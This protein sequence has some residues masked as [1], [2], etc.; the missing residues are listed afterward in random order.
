MEKLETLLD[1]TFKDKEILRLALTHPSYSQST[2]DPNKHYQRLE[3]LGDAILSFILA[4]HLYMLFP[5][6]R[7]GP[8]AKYR[9]ALA[10][11]SF[12]AKLGRR[13]GLSEHIILS[14]AEA[15]TGGAEK[16]SILEDVLEAI[17]AA[18]Y[19]DSDLETTRSTVISWYGDIKNCLDDELKTQNPKGQ[20][21]ELIQK[22]KPEA[23]LKYTLVTTRG[24]D[25]SK[26]YT[27]ELSLDNK[28]L[29]TGSGPSKKE[30]EEAAAQEL[31]ISLKSSS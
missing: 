13:L 18:I 29:A 3:F 9:S 16:D 14:D 30:A 22:T 4:D 11:G 25:H 20:L 27:I 15:K 12:L 5:L 10:Q 26:E 21:Q 31:L 1:Y 23:Q 24:P 19:L 8:L 28:V 7:E 2:K 6:E 17:I